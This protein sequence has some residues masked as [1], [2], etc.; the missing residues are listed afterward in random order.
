V[1]TIS[2]GRMGINK[3]DL[4]DV[5]SC[6]EKIFK[7]FEEIGNAF[8]A[9]YVKP[10]YEKIMEDGKKK[11]WG[12]WKTGLLFFVGY[13]FE[14]QGRPPD[15]AHIAKDV[16]KKINSID[17][18]NEKII[19]KQFCDEW[20]K[21]GELDGKSKDKIGFNIGLNPLAPT[22]TP[23]RKKVIKRVNGE[24]RQVEKTYKTGLSVIR[25]VKEKIRKYQHDI[26]AFS[27]EKLKNG[28]IE[29][30]KNKIKEI[31]GISDK[32]ASFFL[33]DIA[34][35]FEKELELNNLGSNERKYLQPIDIWVKRCCNYLYRLEN[36]ASNRAVKISDYQHYVV[37]RCMDDGK[38]I[39]NPEKVN[40]GMWLFSSQIVGSHYKLS[41][42]FRK[43]TEIIEKMEKEIKKYVART[44]KEIEIL[45][46]FK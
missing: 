27:K 26:V 35:L 6:T 21:L 2:N 33:R 43:E 34:V 45:Q 25:F 30:A 22:N 17:E 39:I 37:E 28:D 15:W 38:Y 46:K 4:R 20:N 12:K 29:G 18:L 40:M 10:E 31:N 9:R 19:W 24:K 23:Y 41:E 11:G 14:R 3:I 5:S 16:I 32:I 13:S 42:I 1:R 36:K 7:K 44:K 8:L